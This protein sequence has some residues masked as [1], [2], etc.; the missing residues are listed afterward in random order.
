MSNGF[1]G[2][3]EVCELFNVFVCFVLDDGLLLFTCNCSQHVHVLLQL[4]QTLYSHIS[5]NLGLKI[6]YR[7]TKMNDI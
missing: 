6:F 2:F 5:D 3:L 7:Q 1:F 4:T